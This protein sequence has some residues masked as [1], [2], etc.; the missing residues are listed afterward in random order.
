M[1]NISTKKQEINDKK[2]EALRLMTESRKRYLEKI[3]EKD[4]FD[5]S[6]IQKD[7]GLCIICCN[8][9][10]MLNYYLVLNLTKKMFK[11]AL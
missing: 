5:G 8:T 2:L 7:S 1:G 10:F 11:Y 6:T 3:L 9:F 4:E